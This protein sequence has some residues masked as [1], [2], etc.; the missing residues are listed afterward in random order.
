MPTSSY[1]V[2]YSYRAVQYTGSNGSEIDAII[3]DFTID[4]ESGG[5]LNFTSN[6]A[7]YVAH[8][9]DWIVYWQH[10]VNSVHSNSDFNLFWVKD[11]LTDE[12]D[13]LKSTVTTLAA[14]ATSSSR[15]VGLKETPTLLLNQSTT[16]SVDVIPAMADT[17]Y[18]PYVQLVGPSTALGSL[19]VTSVSVTDADTVSVVIQNSGL[20]SLS[21]IHCLVVCKSN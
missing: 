4:S 10:Y 2:V 7:S 1:G 3:P 8:T 17:D 19:S 15:S 20:V 18:T 14:G 11:A 9:N 5:T 6:S 13:S 12:L 16:V 21:G